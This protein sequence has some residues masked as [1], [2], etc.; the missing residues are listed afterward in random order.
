M[1]LVSG[2][3]DHNIKVWNQSLQPIS[4]FSIKPYAPLDGSIASLDVRPDDLNS[5]R[6]L[7]ILAGTQGG[8]IIEITSM[9]REGGGAK[10]STAGPSIASGAGISA[11]KAINGEVDDHR[12]RDLTGAEAVALLH[13]HTKGEQWGLATHPVDPDTLATVG[14]DGK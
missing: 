12:N 11:V 8:D 6:K 1:F 9:A 13:S 10:A 4:S 2:G 3:R 7:S 5:T 14:D